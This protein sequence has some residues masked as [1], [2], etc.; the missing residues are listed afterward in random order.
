MQIHLKKNILM[1]NSGEL[2]FLY[3]FDW[4]GSDYNS[5]WQQNFEAPVIEFAGMKGSTLSLSRCLI[6]RLHKEAEERQ[7]EK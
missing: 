4:R 2:K 1:E 3:S 7:W 5:T 6:L